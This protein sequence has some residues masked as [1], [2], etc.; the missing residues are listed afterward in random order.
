[1]IDI[2]KILENAPK[3]LK[4]WSPIFGEVEFLSV[5]KSLDFKAGV[6]IDVHIPSSRYC[7]ISFNSEGKL[8]DNAPDECFLWPSENESFWEDGSWQRAF[9]FVGDIIKIQEGIHQSYIAEITDIL[10]GI[11]DNIKDIYLK[12]SNGT[13]SI[14][15]FKGTTFPS[16]EDIQKF[17][18]GTKVEEKHKGE[19]KPWSLKPFDKF[20]YGGTKKGVWEIGFFGYRE[21]SVVGDPD[22]NWDYFTVGGLDFGTEVLPYNDDTKH[23]H[24]TSEPRVGNWALI[25]TILE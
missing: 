25:P 13:R 2:S 22:Y 6:S 18:E 17:K 5:S 8:E 14:E 16:K 23:L 11:Y 21:V 12:T 1:M 20:L 19:E 15:S 7:Y 24:R 9:F 4:L 10:L 3:G